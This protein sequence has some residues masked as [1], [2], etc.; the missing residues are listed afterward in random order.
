MQLIFMFFERERERERERESQVRS[1][2][3]LAVW[4]PS[5]FD[6]VWKVHKQKHGMLIMGC[7]LTT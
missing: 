5:I 6:L 3:V 1:C 7:F 2:V 4:W